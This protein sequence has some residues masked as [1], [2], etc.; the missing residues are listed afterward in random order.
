MDVLLWRLLNRIRPRYGWVVFL[1]TWAAVLSVPAGVQEARWVWDKEFRYFFVNV[2]LAAGLLALLLAFSRLRGWVVGGVSGLGGVAFVV[3]AVG[4]VLPPWTQTAA[5]FDYLAQWLR[6][7]WVE[8]QWGQMPF[9]SLL[10]D[11]WARLTFLGGRVGEWWSVVRDGGVGRD[12][13]AFL[14]LVGSVVWIATA[15]AMWSVYRWQRPLRGLLLGGAI[16]AISAYHS[17][18]GLAHLL[19]FLA[20]ATFLVPWM[21]FAALVE[22]WERR[23]V[24]YSPEVRMDV[25]VL[26]LLLAVVVVVGGIVM[27]S[28]SIPQ[29]ARWAWERWP[30]AWQSTDEGVWRAFGGIR[31]PAGRGGIPVGMAGLPR[32][33]LLGGSVNLGRQ[34]VMAVTTDDP[35]VPNSEAV[36]PYEEY[37]VPQYYWRALTYDRY[38]GRGWENG[39]LEEERYDA[40]RSLSDAPTEGRRELRQDFVF[41]ATDH[42]AIYAAGDPHWLD[43]PVQAHWRGAGDLAGLEKMA[44]AQEY[45]V[46]SLVPDVDEGVLRRLLPDYPTEIAKRYLQLPGN[47]PQRVLDLAREVTAGASTSY[48]QALALQTYL[49]QFDYSLDLPPPPLDQDVVDY[50]LFDV[51]TG[52]CDYYASAFVVM[53]R[54]VGL[55]ARLAVG[56]AS[57]VYDID[58]GH[59]YVVEKD[60]HSWPEV[61][62]S[63]Y[64]WIEFEP[65]A[66]RSPFEREGAEPL[67]E[68]PALPPPRRSPAGVKLTSNQFL[69]GVGLVVAGLTLWV[70]WARWPRLDRLRS[71]A[72]MA[73]IYRR[74]AWHGARFGVP[75]QSSDTPGEYRC[76]LSLAVDQWVARAG[77]WGTAL[78]T[79][80]RLA[81]VCLSIVEQNYLKA[82]FGRHPLTEDERREVLNAWRNLGRRLWLI[83]LAGK[84]VRTVDKNY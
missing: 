9:Q 41:F 12:N 67:P 26:G 27:P 63:G 1:L 76:R 46:V 4:R 73:T 32:A 58:R 11:A 78:M 13:V 62:F 74:L 43:V 59:Y 37:L 83:W 7:G 45:T 48:D 30:E 40:A 16:L 71:P 28:F 42:A 31:R 6:Q 80:A 81:K 84:A 69:T 36:G 24:D 82:T 44:S 56:Y 10:A 39:A 18:E 34:P 52:Y 8:R 75:L 35:P 20:C 70:G 55:P 54:A 53:A 51:Q 2:A 72:L 79:Q 17:N 29:V 23:K 47:V 65:T 22:S 77:R 61:Y 5:E 38:T 50:F 14:L 3:N 19:V 15:W 68:L 60:A 66:A 64:G 57:G 49:R 21:R 25:A 33:H